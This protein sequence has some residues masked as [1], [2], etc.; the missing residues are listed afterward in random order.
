MGHEATYAPQH[1]MPLFDRFTIPLA[2]WLTRPIGIRFLI[3]FCHR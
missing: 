2:Q 3:F 1:A